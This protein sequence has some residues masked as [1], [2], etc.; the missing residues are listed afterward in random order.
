MVNP[1]E[2]NRIIE[3]TPLPN[4]A[5]LQSIVRKKRLQGVAET[6]IANHISHIY[7][8]LQDLGNPDASDITRGMVED[9][10]LEKKN[11]PLPSGKTVSAATLKGYLIS[12]SVLMQELHGEVGRE[13]TSGIKIKVPLTNVREEELLTED[14][15]KRMMA[16]ATSERDRAIVAVFYSSGARL[17]EICNANIGDVQLKHYGTSIHITKGKTGARDID[18]FIGTP[19]LQNWLN[20]HPCRSDAGAPLFVTRFKKGSQFARLSPKAVQS[21][22]QR[23][24]KAANIPEEKRTN[25]HAFRHARATNVADFLTNSDMTE[26][27][28]WRPGSGMPSVY[29]HSSRKKVAAKLAEHA[30]VKVP[31][32]AKPT[33]MVKQCPNCGCINAAN[34]TTCKYCHSIL[35]E[36]VARYIK[37]IDAYIDKHARELL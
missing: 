35:D 18:I 31:E 28:G 20:V 36:K 26:M 27:F 12:I 23:L 21:L 9:W 10:Y 8:F 15:I 14:E 30:G 1:R 19:E 22:M 17:G 5:Y 11:T 32:S 37:R 6:S 16:A 33:S 29:V 13:Y 7:C 2:L 4:K 34:D 3:Q 25:P 24:A